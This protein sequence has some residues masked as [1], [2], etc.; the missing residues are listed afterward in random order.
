MTPLQEGYQFVP[1]HAAFLVPVSL[2]HGNKD[3]FDPTGPA[4]NLIRSRI[5]YSED[6]AA[7]WR[8]KGPADRLTT[9]CT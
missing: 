8:I 4:F 2:N 7:V 6:V 3:F 1:E 5:V 9:A